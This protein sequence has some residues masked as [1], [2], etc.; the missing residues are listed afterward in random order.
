MVVRLSQEDADRLIKRAKHGFQDVQ[1]LEAKNTHTLP[2]AIIPPNRFKNKWEESYASEV[3][4]P[5]KFM[6]KIQ[7][8]LYESVKFKIGD[9][10]WY[11]PDFF[12]IKDVFEIHEVKGQKKQAGLIKFKTASTLFPWF[13]WIMVSKQKGAWVTIHKNGKWIR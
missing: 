8:W 4:N 1:T 9:G 11:T 5:M 2:T 12:L 13:K 10:V 3:L 7:D 6:G